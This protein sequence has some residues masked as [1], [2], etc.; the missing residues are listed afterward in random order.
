M[1][2]SIVIPVYNSEKILDE[3]VNQLK[4]NLTSLT[5]NFEIILVNDFSKDESW[6]KIKVL[7]ENNN[8]LKGINLIKNHIS[9]T[10]L[11]RG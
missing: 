3:L 9:R 11:C 7:T 1:K 4:K 8:F 10:K 6:K 2:I 5:D